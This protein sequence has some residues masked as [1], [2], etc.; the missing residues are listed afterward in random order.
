MFGKI[1]LIIEKEGTIILRKCKE[2][3]SLLVNFLRWL[4]TAFR[5]KYDTN[6]TG[7]VVL[8]GGSTCTIYSSFYYE[9]SG[10]HKMLHFSVKAGEGDDRGEGIQPSTL[11]TFGGFF[12]R[13]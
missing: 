3:D 13:A 2:M 5:G 4:H 6:V 11:R 9:G 7:N 12:G 10:D 1:E 8:E